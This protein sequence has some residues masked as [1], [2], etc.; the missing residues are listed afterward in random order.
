[1]THPPNMRVVHVTVYGNLPAG[2]RKQ[3]RWEQQAAESLEG[4]EWKQLALHGGA[5]KESFEQRIPVPFRRI[6]L[7]NL[8]AWM[9][10]RRLCRTH[11]FVLLRH[12]PF[13]P[14]VF[15]FAPF[16][17][18][19]IGIHHSKEIQ[20]LPLIRPGLSGRLASWVERVSGRVA[21]RTARA[22]LGVTPEIAAYEADLHAPGKPHFVY[23]NGIDI[24]GVELLPDHRDPEKTEV[25]FICNTFSAWHGLDRLM[26]A[27]GMESPPDSL[28][29]HLIG[30][31]SDRQKEQIKALGEKSGVFQIHGHLESDDYRALLSRCDAGLGSLAMDRQS[32]RQGSTLKVR[33]ML[34][35]GLPVYSGH[36]D[37]SLPD[38]F[39]YYV[40]RRIEIADLCE[41]ARSMKRHTREQI[42]Q[43]SEP[44]IGKRESMQKVVDWLRTL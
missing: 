44:Y 33:E 26:D 7:R 10:I 42:R 20:E 23:A 1:M 4:V 38:D 39:P 24:S 19:R 34:A 28:T 32:L 18:N 16:L 8:Y 5:P 12:M 35:L 27:V 25:A 31:L 40:N 36:E 37:A 11:D 3:I 43:T 17:A 21:V 30:N 13:D 2:V 22:V 6:V 41:F 29:I 14:F 15:F 9:V